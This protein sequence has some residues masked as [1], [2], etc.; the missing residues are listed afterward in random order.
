MPDYRSYK[1]NN[2]NYNMSSSAYAYDY[3]VEEDEKL[4][5]K[6]RMRDEIKQLAVE[7]KERR[8]HRLKLTMAILVVFG[9]S[10][11]TMA[12]HAAVVEQRM[13]NVSLTE[14]TIQL[15]SENNALSAELS[16]KID[17]A[18]VEKEATERLGMTEPQ[19]YQLHYID[20]P[21]QSYT[22]QY[23]V[24]TESEKEKKFS[25]SSIVGLFRK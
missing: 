18:Y 7:K 10:L 5:Q 17:L 8:L 13:I 1:Y 20:V 12:S 23:D 21:K 4:I 19:D 14:Q 11:I 9:G 3:L 15:Q 24:S 2:Q 16:D 25:L 22:V 6:K